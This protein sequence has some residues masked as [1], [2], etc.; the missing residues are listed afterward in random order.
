MK[1]SAF[2]ALVK[3]LK[4]AYRLDRTAV[5]ATVLCSMAESIP[6]YIAIYL[7][8]YVVDKLAEGYAFTQLTSAALL[9]LGIIFSLRML[10]SFLR[11]VKEVHVEKSVLKFDMET[12]KKTLGMD[13]ELLESPFVNEIRNRIRNDNNW[14]AGFYSVFWQLSWLLSSL[15]GLLA[16]IIILAPLLASGAFFTSWTAPVFLLSLLAVTLVASLFSSK[17]TSKKIF[18]LMDESSHKRTYFGYFT[19]E[20]KMDYKSGKDIRLYNAGPMVK[21]YVDAANDWLISWKERFTRAKGVDGLISGSAA[22]VLQGASYLYVVL[23]AASGTLTVGSVL[24]YA[25]AINQLANSLFGFANAFSQ[26]TVTAERQQSTMDYLN[27]SEVMVK[28][29]LPVEKRRDNEYEIEFRDVTFKY[30]GNELY[31]LRHISL[32]FKIGQRLAV[33]GMNGSGKTTLIKLLCRLY[34]P[35]EGEIRLNGIDIRKY[36]C[37][38]YRSIFSV[39]FQDFKLYAF[40]LG[41]NVAANAEYDEQ[42]VEECLSEAGFGER[43]KALREGTKT[44]LFKE[45]DDSGIEISG[46]EAQKIALARALYKDSPFIILDEPTAALDPIAEYEIY[47]KFN[48]IV[49]DKTA[50]YISHRLSSCR[51]CDN[52]AVFHEGQLI[53]LGSH[54]ILLADKRGKYN[55]LWQA[56]A[57]YYMEEART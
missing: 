34:D 37:E 26:L 42:K 50:I 57:Q 55:E 35:T 52:I 6:P 7:S 30:P 22:G 46:G 15:F 2:I 54:D 31:A 21:D 23:W 19:W 56:Q 33:V 8:A 9:G 51:F 13:F 36:N 16:S 45:F 5:I 3:T 25:A 43:Y 1:K 47:S 49:K 20:G 12:D 29:T 18:A 40:S 17:H 44:C 32:K 14:G 48:Q 11:K 28:G 41:Q 53:Q 4:T 10:E 24:K 27:V 39:V 38:E